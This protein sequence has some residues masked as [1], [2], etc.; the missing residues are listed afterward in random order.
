M[1]RPQRPCVRALLLATLSPIAACLAPLSTLA[2]EKPHAGSM[3]GDPGQMMMPAPVGVPGAGMPPPGKP[4]LLYSRRTISNDGLIAGD[5]R[6]SAEWVVLN[7]PNPFA[8]PAQLRRVPLSNTT[9]IDALAISYGITSWLSVSASTAY[10]D[11]T[12]RTLTFAGT[13]GTARRGISLD[14]TEGQGDSRIGANVTLFRGNGQLVHAGLAV[15]LP[16]GS[17]TERITPLMPNGQ[18]GNSRAG[19]TLQLGT[20][21][22]DLAPALTWV[23]TR[24]PIGWGAAYRGRIALEDANDEGY[25]VGDQHVVTG[26]LSYRLTSLLSGSARLEGTS[27]DKIHGRDP[28]ISGPGVGTNPENYGGERIDG[29]LG[30]HARGFVPGLG[31]T[32]LG[33]ELGKPIY[34]NANGV[35]LERD[36][37]AQVSASLRF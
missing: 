33:V 19:Y 7:A 36:W 25:R 21:T 9:H 2:Q 23:G 27:Q 24:G 1:R 8:P 4:M 32:S 28:N 17:I 30:L 13:S 3:V 5:K 20:G 22:Y 6:V 26:W 14:H 16:T 10:L 12:T 31:A 18:I 11:K 15:S 29:Y 35:H 37:S 34:E